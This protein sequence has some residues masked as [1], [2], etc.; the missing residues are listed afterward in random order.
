[1]VGRASTQGPLCDQSDASL[2]SSDDSFCLQ[3]QGKSTQDETKLPAPQHLVTNSAYKLQPSYEEDQIFE[4]KN[5]YLHRNQDYTTKCVH[6]D[7]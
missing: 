2:S 1:M 6:V 3:M 4:S 5:R 7:F